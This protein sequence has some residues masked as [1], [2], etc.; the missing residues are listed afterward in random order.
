MKKIYE[1]TS[2][3][4]LCVLGFL[5]LSLG[6]N[7]QTI[8]KG[9]VTDSQKNLLPGV[10]VL[11]PSGSGT[12]TSAKGEYSLTLPDGTYVITFSMVGYK[13]VIKSVVLKGETVMLDV[14]LDDSGNQ[15]NEVVVNR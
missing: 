10:S 12:I 8:I 4:V 7:A 15:L 9:K 5:I 11:P 3:R 6:A 2:F 1:K 13:K 14:L